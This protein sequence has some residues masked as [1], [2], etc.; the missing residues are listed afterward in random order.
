MAQQPIAS[1]PSDTTAM[2][3]A[4]GSGKAVVMAAIAVNTH[5]PAQHARRKCGPSTPGGTKRS[6]QDN[7]IAWRSGRGVIGSFCD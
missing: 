4:M 3:T 5:V 6:R 7:G 1:S 2:G